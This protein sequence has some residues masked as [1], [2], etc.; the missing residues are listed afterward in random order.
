MGEGKSG[1]AQLMRQGISYLHARAVHSRGEIELKRVDGDPPFA[2]R[3]G[4]MKCHQ[5]AIASVVSCALLVLCPRWL[6]AQVSTATLGGRVTD[7]SGAV[8][9]DA[10]VHATNVATNLDYPTQTNGDGLYNLSSLPPGNYRLS[11]EKDGF[12]RALVPGIDLH[13]G[14]SVAMNFTLQPGSLAQSVQVTAAAPLVESTTSSLGSLVNENAI[15]DLPLNGRSYDQLALTQPGVTI[16]SPGPPNTSSTGAF[17]FGTAQRF[18]V[19][20]QRP[21]S[22]SFLLDGTDVN[23]QSNGT[24][25]DAAGLNLG[26]D[27]ILEFKI[28]TNSYAAEFGRSDGGVISSVTRSGTNTFH[29][30]AF[31]YIRKS[32]LDASNFFDVNHATPPFRRNQFGGVFGGP[33]KKDKA[34]FFVGYEGLRQA[35]ATTQHQYYVSN[36]SLQY[37][38]SCKFW[39]SRYQRADNNWC[40]ESR[41]R[42]NHV[43]L[44][45]FP[46]ASICAEDQ[47]LDSNC[48]F[49]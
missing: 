42:P 20:G 12:E 35:L 29:G 15:R 23:D 24:P 40:G 16:A 41:C 27:T 46:T 6:F 17:S 11:A 44:Y 8:I 39:A 37:P 13:V 21:Y 1:V 2:K 34:F 4:E 43:H 19:G 7:S 25:G 3:G 49:Q 14:D 47:F 38:E 31:E 33:I 30:T 9:I 22:N 28:F 18:S 32:V 48:W 26:V 10:R 45:D 36:R 5:M